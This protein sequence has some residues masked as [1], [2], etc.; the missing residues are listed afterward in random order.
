MPTQ[1]NVE[2]DSSQLVVLVTPHIVRRPHDLLTGPRIPV[3]T[4]AN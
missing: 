1:D 4:E 2:K 3:R